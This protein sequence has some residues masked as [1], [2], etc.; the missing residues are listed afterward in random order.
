[1]EI[2]YLDLFA[3]TGGFAKGLLEAGFKFTKHYFSEVDKW[4]IANYHHNYSQA[5]Y[6]GKVEQV[7]KG[8]IQ[9]PNIITFGSPCQDLS[10]AGKG[11]G[12]RKGSRSSLF[13]E[14]VRIIDEFRP[15][16]FVFENVKGLFSSREGKDFETVLQAFADL[17]VYDIQ[18][19]LVNSS[20]FLPQSRERIYAVGHHR[21][22]GSPQVFPLFQTYSQ[23]AS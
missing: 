2:V 3:G 13:F 20:W 8:Q 16:F 4:A 5:E 21:T 17:G 23:S 7:S 22:Q 15:D 11:K 12:L 10:T 18:W 6:V 14:A 19:Q 1:M 9:R